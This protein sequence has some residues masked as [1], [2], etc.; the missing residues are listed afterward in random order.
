MAA[1]ILIIERNARIGGLITSQ[2]NSKGFEAADV[3]HGAEAA[4][5]LRAGP[6]DLVLLDNQVV[7]GGVKTA[8]IAPQISKDAYRALFAYGCR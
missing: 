1:K 7:M 4:V 3:R 2:L 8:Q 6:A 5:A